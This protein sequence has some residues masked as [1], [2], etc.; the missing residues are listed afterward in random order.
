MKYFSLPHPIPDLISIL[1]PTGTEMEADIYHPK[2]PQPSSASPIATR[3]SLSLF[4]S[5]VFLAIPLVDSSGKR[6]QAVRKK[7]W[8]YARCWL[9][10][11]TGQTLC[12]WC[13]KAIGG[14]LRQQLS[15]LPVCSS[16]TWA[17]KHH[18]EHP[19][20]LKGTCLGEGLGERLYKSSALLWIRKWLLDSPSLKTGPNPVVLQGCDGLLER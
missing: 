18:R 4:S 9:P 16:E 11:S 20:P 2:L 15:R 17:N 1:W 3:R 13:T 10:G 6:F 8:D 5:L 14:D 12:R 19:T 7:P